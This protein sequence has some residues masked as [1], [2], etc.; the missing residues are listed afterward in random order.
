[1]T[2]WFN[3]KECLP[4]VQEDVLTYSCGRMSIQSFAPNK[5]DGCCWGFYPGGTP[6]ENV[7]N[8]AFL[9]DPSRKEEKT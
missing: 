2:F 6:I 7:Q 3:I 8:W 9:P 5:G 4:P 1:M